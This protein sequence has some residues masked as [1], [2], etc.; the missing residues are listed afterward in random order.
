MLR[1]GHSFTG[2]FEPFA[3]A[4][5]DQDLCDEAFIGP[6]RLRIDQP[7]LREIAN[8]LEI[9]GEI[10]NERMEMR[11]FLRRQIVKACN[12]AAKHLERG[13]IALTA[14]QFML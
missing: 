5:R 11:L 3:A 7:V 9:K 2:E 6:E 13:G 12:A 10:D 8:H 14:S 1:H 4:G